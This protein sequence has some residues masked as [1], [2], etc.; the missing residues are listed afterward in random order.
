MWFFRSL[1]ALQ[2]GYPAYVC[3]M[4]KGTQPSHAHEE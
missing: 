4:I 1:R 2:L 3:W